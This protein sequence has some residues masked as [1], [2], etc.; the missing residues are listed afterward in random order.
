[1]VRRSKLRTLILVS[2]IAAIGNQTFSQNPPAVG[3]RLPAGNW[4]VALYPY[5]GPEFE[6]MPLQVIMVRG[7]LAHDG[8]IF[9]IRE[10]RLRNRSDKRV[11]KASFAAFIYTEQ[12][13]EKL[14]FQQPLGTVGLA[15]VP[16]LARS[17]WPAPCTDPSKYCPYGHGI[18]GVKKLLAP[19]IKESSPEGEPCTETGICVQTLEGEYRIAIGVSKVW[20]EDGSIWELP[21]R[22]TT[23]KIQPP[24]RPS[25]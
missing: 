2:F 6:S 22:P 11:L 10:R 16:V 20:F 1:M 7:E 3:G 5:S 12:N 13:P 19:L 8:T 15:R 25:H 4:K 21:G 18:P 17:E 24:E 14:L 9:W 23:N